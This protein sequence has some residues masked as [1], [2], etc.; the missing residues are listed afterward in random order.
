MLDYF[1][2]KDAYDKETRTMKIG[3]IIKETALKD[4]RI[5]SLKRK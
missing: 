5:Q 4:F 2:Y 3:E 1:Y